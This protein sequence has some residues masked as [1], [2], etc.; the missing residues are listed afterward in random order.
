LGVE[1]FCAWI[2]ASFPMKLKIVNVTKVKKL[3]GGSFI[4]FLLLTLVIPALKPLYIKKDE[5]L[6]HKELGLWIKENFGKGFVI[7]SRKPWVSFYSESLW[8]AYPYADYEKIMDFAKNV[9][10]DFFVI[11][12]RTIPSTRPQL[13]FLL[14]EK[15]APSY[16]KLVKELHG[17]EQ[18]ILLYSVDFTKYQKGE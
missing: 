4:M 14:D 16:L 9:K 2:E 11:D 12:T 15:K 13:E 3:I 1:H 10:A 8:H 7:L 6:E 5:P 17:A 18:K